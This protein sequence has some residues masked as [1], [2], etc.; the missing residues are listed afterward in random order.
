MRAHDLRFRNIFPSRRR[1][2]LLF[3]YFLMN[4][5]KPVFERVLGVCGLGS[6]YIFFRSEHRYYPCS[7]VCFF[8][9]RLVW[10]QLCYRE[11]KVRCCAPCTM[12]VV[13]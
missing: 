7:S 2:A 12:I 1:G 10:F 11:I 4:E 5:K 13:Q 3:H 6:L 8:S 9:G